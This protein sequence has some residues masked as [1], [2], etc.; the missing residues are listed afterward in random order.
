MD[1]LLY[2]AQGMG[3]DFLLN[4]KNNKMY[5]DLLKDKVFSVRKKAIESLKNLIQ[6][7]GP[8][9]FEKNF[10]PKLIA[11]QKLNSYLQRETFIFAA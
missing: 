11:F 7:H 10:L 9:W 5:F 8:A 4:E 6:I 3:P 1:I 2:F